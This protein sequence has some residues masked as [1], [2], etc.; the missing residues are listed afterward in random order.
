MRNP[1]KVLYRE[2]IKQFAQMYY[3]QEVPARVVEAKG[4]GAPT[5]ARWWE[6][7]TEEDK[8]RATLE[9][10][11]HDF[12]VFYCSGGTSVE[13]LLDF[14]DEV[15]CEETPEGIVTPPSFF[16]DVDDNIDY[17]SPLN[18][19][20]ATIG[21]RLPES[22]LL[23]PGES[24]NILMQDGSKLT[25]WE[26][27]KT[28]NYDGEVFDVVRNQE[29]VASLHRVLKRARGVSFTTERLRD[30]YV[31]TYGLENTY[32]F[33]NSVIFED[34]P[35]IRLKKS[36][37]V[38]RVLWQ[39]GDSHYE[40]WYGLRDALKEV[41]DKLPEVRFVIWGKEFPW[42]HG[43]IPRDRIEVHDWV[44]YEAY[45]IKLAAMDFDIALAPLVPNAFN[46]GKSCIKWY[47][48]SALPEP[49]PVLA[50]N[51]PPYSDEMEDG[52]TGMLYDTPGDFVEKLGRLVGDRK[53]RGRLAANAKDWVN[54]HRRADITVPPYWDW[55]RSSH[56]RFQ[57]RA[58]KAYMRVVPPSVQ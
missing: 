12:V 56:A 23:K 55:L 27:G 54:E 29:G 58:R 52:V 35:D 20:F 33:P 45:K 44:P 9:M 32:A 40:D 24:V 41:C 13:R 31:K 6:V 49:R 18:H 19:K 16:E 37:G 30:Y 42:V 2:P 3:R 47:E 11:N 51:T 26:D 14:L 1:P 36:K 15:G 28:S 57:E 21:T 7:T 10:L 5:W 38:V 8:E 17:V 50:A 39:G 48:A 53:L 34:Y 4:L 22:G 25:V 43:V 46:E